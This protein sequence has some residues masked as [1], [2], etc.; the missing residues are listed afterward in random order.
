M[1]GVGVFAGQPFHCAATRFPLDTTFACEDD[2]NDDGESGGRSGE[3]GHHSDVGPA[4]CQTKPFPLPSIPA[5]PPGRG[6][7]WD[8][9]KGCT[10]RS[11]AQLKLHPNL[12]NL[13]ML[14]EYAKAQLADEW[15]HDVERDTSAITAHAARVAEWEKA[16][17]AADAE[18]E[19][20]TRRIEHLTLL[21]QD[22]A[23]DAAETRANQKNIHD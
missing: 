19:R 18:V 17:L 22:A 5:S 3:S 21:Q 2:D 6:L 23:D 13:T 1:R 14:V 9:C 4:G 11:L 12:V 10:V 16:I 8:H 7:L 20:V 15:Q